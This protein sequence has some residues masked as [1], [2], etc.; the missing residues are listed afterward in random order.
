[1][2]EF[3]RQWDA[4][5][6]PMFLLIVLAILIGGLL[7][8]GLV[9]FLLWLV[10]SGVITLVVRSVY[11]GQLQADYNAE[12]AALGW[13]FEGDDAFGVAFGVTDLA[14]QRQMDHFDW[15]TGI[16]LGAEDENE[17]E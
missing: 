15:L 12:R 1:M 10:I 6:Y 14:R 2:S 5:F 3:E 17:P 9:A 13:D 7:T 11:R 16:V 8:I 4:V